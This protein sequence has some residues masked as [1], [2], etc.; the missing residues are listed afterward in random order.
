M[1]LCPPC[2]C[3]RGWQCCVHCAVCTWRSCAGSVSV[4]HS[5]LTLCSL[6]S[7]RSCSPPRQS[8]SRGPLTEDSRQCAKTIT[9][10][11]KSHYYFLTESIFLMMKINENCSELIPCRVF[12]LACVKYKFQYFDSLRIF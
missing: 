12:L 7:T 3:T 5:L 4:T 2:R 1:C 8:C 9:H 10:T 6:H 11:L